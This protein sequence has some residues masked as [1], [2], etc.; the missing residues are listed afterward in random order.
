M[1]EVFTW[2]A[3][4]ACRDQQER[5][6]LIGDHSELALE[7]DQPSVL[8]ARRICEPNLRRILL[9][10]ANGHCHVLDEAVYSLQLRAR[11]L[12]RLQLREA[13]AIELGTARH[14][15]SP[16]A[17][18]ARVGF[19]CSPCACVRRAIEHDDVRDEPEPPARER[20]P[21]PYASTGTPSS[22][23]SRM[24]LTLIAPDTRILMSPNPSASSALRTVPDETWVHSGWHEATHQRNDRLVHEVLRRRELHTP[25]TTLLRT[26]NSERG[27]NGVVVVVYRNHEQRV[28]RC[29][30]YA[31]AHRSNGITTVGCDER[32]RHEHERRLCT[33]ALRR[34]S[35]LHR[36]ADL[37]SHRVAALQ[38]PMIIARRQRHHGLGSCRLDERSCVRRHASA[39]RKHTDTER[40]EVREQIE[41]TIDGH[42]RLVCVDVVAVVKRVH[43]SAATNPRRPLSEQQSPHRSRRADLTAHSRIVRSRVASVGRRSGHRAPRPRLRGRSHHAATPP[44][45]VRTMRPRAF[46]LMRRRGI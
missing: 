33:R 42:H 26:R 14:G 1:N 8:P 15:A 2:S 11:G 23:N 39:T 45:E 36:A 29:V 13:S 5:G 30:S 17:L 32:M 19:E 21:T 20:V 10:R 9:R 27:R 43:A 16:N 35:E 22:S 38:Q 31:R 37:R 46:T 44:Q 28:V 7:Q 4:A 18:H 6:D 40:S 24:R 34:T 3:T 41:A 12:E 25:H